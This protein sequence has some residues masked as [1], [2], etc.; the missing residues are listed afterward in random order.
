MLT[1]QEELQEEFV[2]VTCMECETQCLNKD[3]DQKHH[4][5]VS[6]RDAV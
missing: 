2:Q 4:L 1:H 3:P 6:S 5:S